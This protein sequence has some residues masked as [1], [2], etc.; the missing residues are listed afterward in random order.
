[1][2]ETETSPQWRTVLAGCAT[3]SL[4][5]AYL[6]GTHTFLY[7]QICTLLRYFTQL[8]ATVPVR[9][10]VC[11]FFFLLSSSVCSHMHTV[12]REPLWVL[13]DRSGQRHRKR[14][15]RRGE[16]KNEA[17]KQQKKKVERTSG[18][19]RSRLFDSYAARNFEQLQFW[20]KNGMTALSFFLMLSAS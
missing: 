20:Y 14:N 1:M 13:F 17:N 18:F 19:R 12:M 2:Y 4:C 16:K 10:G 7:T 5:P 9:H 8:S 3:S 15:E 11:H 6:G